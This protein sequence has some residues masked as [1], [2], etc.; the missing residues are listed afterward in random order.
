MDNLSGMT[1][2]TGSSVTHGGGRRNHWLVASLLVFA[3]C[4]AAPHEAMGGDEGLAAGRPQAS[5]DSRRN[6]DAE[7]D[8]LPDAQDPQEE[9]GRRM[10]HSG[11]MALEVARP[12]DQLDAAIAKAEELGGY[13]SRRDDM[14]VTLRVPA[15]EFDALV[16]WV[17]GRGRVLR[18]HLQAHEVTEEYR[19]LR[20]RLENAKEARDRVLALLEKADAVKDVLTIEKELNRLTLEIERLEGKLRVLEHRIALATLVV[21]FHAVAPVDTPERRR[22]RFSWINRVGGEYV[23][24]MF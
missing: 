6:L 3:A 17:R 5:S 4:K 24:R 18:Q 9:L 22:S 8:D 13:D 21:S 14:E 1:R 12:G 10:V 7:F 2:A 15:E 19:D 23:L 20:I 16:E 11:R